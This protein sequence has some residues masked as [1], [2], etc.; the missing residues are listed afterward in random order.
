MPFRES[1]RR[2][3]KPSS[4]SPPATPVRSTTSCEFSDGSAAG[5]GANDEKRLF[6]S[7]DI[8]GQ[9][10]VRRRVGP[11]LFA[12]VESH[13][14]PSFVR[15]VIAHRAAKHGVLRLDG[16]QNGPLRHAPVHGE[17]YLAADAR[18]LTQR[19]W[20]YDADHC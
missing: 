6:A 13:E 7:G 3:A 19:S 16:I 5:E 11:V 15:D 20:Q 17:L 1:A 10:V 18:Q 2:C 12:G 8:L 14:C 9:L 4:Y